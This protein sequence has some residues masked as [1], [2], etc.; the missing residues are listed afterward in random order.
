MVLE[1]FFMHHSNYKI[2]IVYLIVFRKQENMIFWVIVIITGIFL[3]LWHWWQFTVDVFRIILQEKN[4]YVQYDYY[5]DI[6]FVIYQMNINK[7]I[8]ISEINIESYLI[9]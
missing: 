4:L 3:L 9:R 1:D 6:I 5:T 2:I 7:L 8:Q